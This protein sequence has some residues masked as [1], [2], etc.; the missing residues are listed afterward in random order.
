M[1]KALPDTW[2]T[3]ESAAHT[4]T[5]CVALARVQYVISQAVDNTKTQQKINLKRKRERGD[6]MTDAHKCCDINNVSEFGGEGATTLTAASLAS[7]SGHKD[8]R[9]NG[10]SDGICGGVFSRWVNERRFRQGAM[11]TK[12]GGVR[13]SARAHLI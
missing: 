2:T 8:D 1:D 11:E 13:E 5:V 7:M 10:S 3:P 9:E 4:Y 6:R 12:I